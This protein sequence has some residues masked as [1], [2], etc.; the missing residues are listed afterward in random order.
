M[1]KHVFLF[2]ATAAL[3]CLS[4]TSK[5]EDEINDRQQEI[6][7]TKVDFSYSVSDLT[8]T[9]T[10][11]CD[12]KVSRFVWFVD[13]EGI[14][15]TSKKSYTYTF[16]KSGTY[17]V[18]LRGLWTTNGKSYDKDVSKDITVQESPKNYTKI[19]IYGIKYIAVD[20]AYDYY[21][22]KLVDD[23]VF[24]TTW[25]HTN[26]TD[27]FLYSDKLPYTYTFNAPV[28]MS[29]LNE[30]NYY[31]LYVYHSTWYDGTEEIQCLKQNIQTSTFKDAIKN[32]KPY[33]QVQNNSGNTVVQL[34][35]SYE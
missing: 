13:D 1:K 3:L 32:A 21:K 18:T 27:I 26:F 4:C 20:V 35:C 28:E 23:D 7:S 9:L 31:T 8:V 22:A 34:L 19:F 10:A 25:W 29:G 2:A 16:P 33:I 30:D 14:V 12:A 6:N 5:I 11:E 24:T 15:E 17:K